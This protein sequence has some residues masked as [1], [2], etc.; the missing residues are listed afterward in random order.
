MWSGHPHFSAMVLIVCIS[1]SSGI[2]IIDCND[3]VVAVVTT[4]MSFCTCFRH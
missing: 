1:L 3:F 4:I 2:Q